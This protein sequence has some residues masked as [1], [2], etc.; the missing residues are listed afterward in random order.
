M[1]TVIFDLGK[2][3]V[4]YD[5]E[6]FLHKFAFDEKT[7][8]AVADAVFLSETWQQGDA[9]VYDEATWL[10]AF[11]ANAPAYEKEIRQVYE[12]LAGCVWT[13]P[14]TK[15]LIA[16]FRKEGYRI[17]YLSNYSEY[18][19]KA[20]ANTLAFLKSFDGGV[21]SYEVKCVKPEEKIYKILLERYDIK[22]DDA[23]FY[24]DRIENVEAAKRLGIQGI[25]WTPGMERSILRD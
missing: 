20:S 22:T 6:Q 9:G 4:Q 8:R 25:L 10:D 23:L 14:Y 13:F 11:L 1:K 24:D 17:Y 3:L 21:F 16:H 7:F 5:W 2:V 15:E 18:L 19:R 12:K